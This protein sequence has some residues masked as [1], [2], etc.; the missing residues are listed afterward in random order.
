MP[1]EYDGSDTGSDASCNTSCESGQRVQVY[2]ASK[3]EW[4]KGKIGTVKDRRATVSYQG[5]QKVVNLDDSSL[6]RFAQ[7]SPKQS[8]K[9]KRQERRQRRGAVPE[10]ETAETRAARLER[11]AHAELA[12]LLEDDEEL[13]LQV[14]DLV[15]DPDLE[16]GAELELEQSSERGAMDSPR[17]RRPRERRERRSR[18]SKQRES[19][20]DREARLERES[21]AELEALTGGAEAPAA[22]SAA[23]PSKK[24]PTTPI[25][26]HPANEP[27]M[28]SPDTPRSTGDFQEIEATAAAV[29]TAV[30]AK[31][32][33]RVE[34]AVEAAQVEAEANA[35][36]KAELRAQE[37][38]ARLDEAERRPLAEAE[39]SRRQV[40]LIDAEKANAEAEVAAVEEEAA[41]VQAQAAALDMAEARA[42]AEAEAETA[43]LAAEDSARETATRERVRAQAEAAAAEAATEAAAEAAAETAAARHG[44][45]EA[46]AARAREDREEAAAIAE[47]EEANG[48]AFELCSPKAADGLPGKALDDL[49]SEFLESS[50]ARADESLV[51]AVAAATAAVLG[52]EDPAAAAAA[53]SAGDSVVSAAVAGAQPLAAP[54]VPP[55]MLSYLTAAEQADRI[56]APAAA[57]EEA[58]PLNS[59]VIWEF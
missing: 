14:Q 49:Y 22:D 19:A 26:D 34:E 4:V 2:S 21:A 50:A 58:L 54:G 43:R 31:K 11:E 1:S 57:G 32:S 13:V 37:A 27:S 35:G 12:T 53:V 24:P 6:V 41:A 10:A 47:A 17:E 56:E 33:L 52:A 15:L 5:R 16:P 25:R 39:V 36:A 18:D 42:K 30:R 8:P 29:A 20:D 55:L 23:E 46:V 59:P 28:L 48:F 3:K 9:Q 40:E 44:Q 45:E 38:A 51:A 7:Q